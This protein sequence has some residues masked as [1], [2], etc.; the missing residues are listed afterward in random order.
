MLSRS[1]RL[2]AALLQSDRRRLAASFLAPL[3]LGLSF[4]C[5]YVAALSVGATDAITPVDQPL[6]ATVDHGPARIAAP[7][8]ARGGIV[9]GRCFDVEVDPL[10]PIQDRAPPALAS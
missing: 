6:V 10:R 8:P 3:L 9:V 4:G 5:G 1:S 2:I 7:Q